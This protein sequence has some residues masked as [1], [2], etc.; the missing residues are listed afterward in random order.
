MPAKPVYFGSARQALLD[1]K[2]TLP[3]KLDLILD[4]LKVRDRVRGERVCI[5]MHLGGNID[6]PRSIRSSSARLFRP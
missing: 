2:E 1:A 6:T 4:E 3:A 5:K